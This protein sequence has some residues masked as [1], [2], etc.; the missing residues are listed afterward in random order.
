MEPLAVIAL[1]VPGGNV[2]HD[3][4]AIDVIHGFA[5]GDVGPF[6]ADD[7]G[8]FAFIIEFLRDVL[9]RIDVVIRADDARRGFCEE[10]GELGQFLELFFM[11]FFDVFGV[12][13]TDAENIFGELPDRRQD[14]Y[15]IDRTGRY[16]IGLFVLFQ[17]VGQGQEPFIALTDEFFQR[18][19]QGRKEGFF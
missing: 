17:S 11:E 6:F 10:L 3:S 5:D 8:Q 15:R 14:V 18:F 12:I 4:K 1:Q 9:V 7:D 16:G 13:F 2:V 19:R